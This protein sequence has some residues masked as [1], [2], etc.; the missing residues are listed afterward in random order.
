MQSSKYAPEYLEWRINEFLKVK[1]AEGFTDEQVETVRTALIQNSK[2]VHMNLI[3]EANTQWNELN[4]DV[5]TFDSSERLIDALEQVTTEQVNAKF[6]DV[7]FNGARRLN[8]KVIAEEH[9]GNTEQIDAA[10]MENE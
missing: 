7:F 2:Q 10:R 5:L 9:K 1:L 8:V 4:R 6:A 3:Q